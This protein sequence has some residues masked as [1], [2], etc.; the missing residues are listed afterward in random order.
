MI[1]PKPQRRVPKPRKYIARTTKPAKRRKTSQAAK[2]REA[3]KLFSRIIRA[4]RTCYYHFGRG[5][6][7]PLGF[8]CSGPLQCAHIVSRIYR[9]VRWDEG[10]A[11]PLCAGAHRYMTSRPLEWERFVLTFMPAADYEGLKLRALEVW[12]H[13]MEPVL[14]RLRQRA[15]ELG[16]EA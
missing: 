6:L 11:I 12:D 14:D 2:V 4:G 9:S 10:N 16:V 3:D 13:D 8:A 1:Q 5:K 7:T 15:A